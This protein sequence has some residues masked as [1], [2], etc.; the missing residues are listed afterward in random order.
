MASHLI[1]QWVWYYL[2]YLIDLTVLAMRPE[3]KAA[4]D[5]KTW[6]LPVP[7]SASVRSEFPVPETLICT[8]SRPSRPGTTVSLAIGLANAGVEAISLEA[9]VW[10]YLGFVETFRTLEGIDGSGQNFLEH[11]QRFY[12]QWHFR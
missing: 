6:T 9:V 11:F 8:L 12:G 1:F 4:R 7:A 5:C 2:E 3:Y 10:L